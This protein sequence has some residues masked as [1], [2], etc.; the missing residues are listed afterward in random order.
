MYV[1]V[2]VRVCLGGVFLSFC[3][4]PQHYLSCAC[5]N[6]PIDTCVVYINIAQLSWQPLAS[7]I[8]Y[9]FAFVHTR[10]CTAS[11]LFLSHLSLIS[12]LSHSHLGTAPSHSSHSGSSSDVVAAGIKRRLNSAIQYKPSKKVK[13]GLVRK[14]RVC[15]FF[16][17]FLFL[18]TSKS[19]CVVSHIDFTPPSHMKH[20]PPNQLLS[21]IMLPYTSQHPSQIPMGILFLYISLCVLLTHFLCIIIET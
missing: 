3:I 4:H 15:F 6:L 20:P 9:S 12:H 17:C 2:C 8:A 16:V 7:S 18:Q 21:F 11:H 13:M 10:T 19:N 14:E 5:S 1:C